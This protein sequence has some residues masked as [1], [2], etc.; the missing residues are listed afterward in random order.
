M[1]DM[2]YWYTQSLWIQVS[3]YE[4]FG[5]WFRGLSTFSDSVWIHRELWKLEYGYWKYGKY[6]MNGTYGE[7][8]YHILVSFNDVI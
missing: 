2:I 8:N 5:V 1:L 3:Y 7:K 6:M 4:V